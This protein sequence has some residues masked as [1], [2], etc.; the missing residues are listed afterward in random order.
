MKIGFI[1]PGREFSEKFLNSWTGMLKSIPKEWDWFHITGYAPNVFYNRQALLDRAKM[2][3]PTHYMWIDSDQVF[4]FSMLEKLVNYN[5]PI[6]SGIYKKTPDIFA[7]CGLDGRTLTVN[8][9]KNQTDLIEVKANGMGFM[10][11]KREVLDYIIDPFEPIDPDQ[12]EDFTFQEK[13]RQKGYK[14]YIDPT[15]IVGHEK[16]ILL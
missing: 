5:L 12:W 9:I 14:S 16:K 1:L 11:V 10:L 3:R 15:I 6:I 7:C 2:L 8:D 13:A 4:N